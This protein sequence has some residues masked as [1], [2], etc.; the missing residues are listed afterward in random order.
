MTAVLSSA[1]NERP[2]IGQRY[3]RLGQAEDGPEAR[4]AYALDHIEEYQRPWA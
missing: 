1:G 2:A 4:A 3:P